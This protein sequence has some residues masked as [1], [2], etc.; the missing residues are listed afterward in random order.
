VRPFLHPLVACLLLS[1]VAVAGGHA[2]E[3]EARADPDGQKSLD[4][5]TGEWQVDGVERKKLRESL[6]ALQRSLT[7]A[8]ASL[9]R[10]I[11]VAET[12]A[13]SLT[14]SG[15]PEKLARLEAE[16]KRASA[17]AAR[18]GRAGSRPRAERARSRPA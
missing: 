15:V 9:A 1:L 12:T 13:T 7:R 16:E 8:N 14:R 18:A 6:A 10:A 3:S 2:G 4:I 5:A 11:E 17:M